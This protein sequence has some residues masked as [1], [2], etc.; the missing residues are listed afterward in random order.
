MILL[1]VVI[2]LLIYLFF[3]KKCFNII[4]NFDNSKQQ[5]KCCLIKKEYVPDDNSLYNAI[6]K[7]KYNKLYD[8]S[9]NINLHEQNSNQQL[10]I[11][12]QNNWDNNL[13]TEENT[14]VGSCRRNNKECVDF[15]QKKDC[16]KY[17]MNWYNKSCHNAIPFVFSDNIVKQ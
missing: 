9:C 4:D 17:Y 8:D 15:L 12:G 10:F 1:L 3:G 5:K 14:A 6:F 11:D 7:Y 2:I 13:C 16:D